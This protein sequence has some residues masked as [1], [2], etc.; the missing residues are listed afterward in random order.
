MATPDIRRDGPM[1][2]GDRG[3]FDDGLVLSEPRWGSALPSAGEEKFSW[4]PQER[5]PARG[6]D[7]RVN[8]PKRKIFLTPAAAWEKSRRLEFDS[9]Y[10]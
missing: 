3:I 8:A 2:G 7:A 9:D 1:I 5:A 4:S 10:G 6:L